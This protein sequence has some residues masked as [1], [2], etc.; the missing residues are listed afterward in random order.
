M[1]PASNSDGKKEAAKINI[2]VSFLTVSSL[3]VLLI[4]LP[5]KTYA[6]N[7]SC[8]ITGSGACSYVDT[9]TKSD[10]RHCDSGCGGCGP[11]PPPGSDCR[12]I[13]D[14]WNEY[15]CGWDPLDPDVCT[16]YC[17][18]W[19]RTWVCD[20][21]VRYGECSPGDTSSCTCDNGC[22]GTKTCQ[23][24][25]GWGPCENCGTPDT[26]CSSHPVTWSG[27]CVGDLPCGPGTESGTCDNGC[28]GTGTTSRECCNVCCSSPY[29][30]QD[31]WCGGTCSDSDDY[32]T[33]TPWTGTYGGDCDPSCGQTRTRTCTNACSED[34][35][36][37]WDQP[38][39]AESD[40]CSDCDIG[41][42]GAPD[43]LRPGSSSKSLP[44]RIRTSSGDT[45]NG[46][47]LSQTLWWDN[48]DSDRTCDGITWPRTDDY[49]IWVKEWPWGT[50]GLETTVVDG[51]TVDITDS[52]AASLSS[53][54][55]SYTLNAKIGYEYEWWT[56]GRNIH[57]SEEISAE[58]EHGFVCRPDCR[59]LDCGQNGGCG[60]SETRSDSWSG[61]YNSG[62]DDCY[63]TDNNNPS[64]PV[65]L[66]VS[67][68]A[69]Y[70]DRRLSGDDWSDPVILDFSGDSHKVYFFWDP[71]SWNSQQPEDEFMIQILDLGD[72]QDV[73][74]SNCCNP[75]NP[76]ND[77][78]CDEYWTEPTDWSKDFGWDVQV[79]GH[80]V[81]YD[82]ACS[83]GHC[84]WPQTGTYLIQKHHL[85]A[86]RVAAHNVT[87]ERD[88][89]AA[90][91]VDVSSNVGSLVGQ[92][93]HLDPD[94]CPNPDTCGGD[95]E[96]DW[97]DWT[98]G[99][100]M[101]LNQYPTATNVEPTCNSRNGDCWSG[102]TTYNPENDQTV[103]PW[104]GTWQQ[105]WDSPSG[106]GA[107]SCGG[108]CTPCA[109]FFT[110]SSCEAQLGCRWVGGVLGTSTGAGKDIAATHPPGGSFCSGDC[111]SCQDLT[112]DTC[113]DQNGCRLEDYCDAHSCQDMV[114][115]N[116]P[117]VFIAT[118][119][120]PDGWE[121]LRRLHLTFTRPGR[122]CQ[123]SKDSN[124]GW[125][126][127]ERTTSD[128][129]CD[130][131]IADA[132]G[133]CITSSTHDQAEWQFLGGKIERDS[134]S[135]NRLKGYFKVRFDRGGS[136]S[137]DG[138]NIKI[139]ISA[140]DFH[141]ASLAD[142]D[143]ITWYGDPSGHPDHPNGEVYGTSG[144]D[145]DYSWKIDLVPPQRDTSENDPM[146]GN[147]I[148]DL[149][150]VDVNGDGSYDTWAF[151]IKL[152]FRDFPFT[153]PHV[154]SKLFADL[155]PNKLSPDRNGNGIVTFEG[156]MG[157]QPPNLEEN[158]V[159]VLA[160]YSGDYNN[161]GTEEWIRLPYEDDR[162]TYP[163]YYRVEPRDFSGGSQV[164]VTL[165]VPAENEPNPISVGG[166]DIYYQ[167]TKDLRI[168]VRDQA[169]N[170]YDTGRDLS[171]FPGWFQAING[172][173]YARGE[174][175]VKVD[176]VTVSDYS[177]DY[178]TYFL[179]SEPSP[180]P[181]DTIPDTSG[182]LVL[183][184][185]DI[186]TGTT[187]RATER[188]SDSDHHRWEESHYSSSRL[189]SWSDALG[190]NWSE[191]V[192]SVKSS[193]NQLDFS[194]DIGS[195]WPKLTA[196]A[197]YEITSSSLTSGVVEGEYDLSG[198]GAAI[199]YVAG[200]TETTVDGTPIRGLVIG[201]GDKATGTNTFSSKDG[202]NEGVILIVDGDVYIR[203]DIQRVDAF[204]IATGSITFELGDTTEPVEVNGSL[205][206][207][208]GIDVSRYIFDVYKPVLRVKYNGLYISSA[209]GS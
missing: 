14:S 182:G 18:D 9:C 71:A 28:G 67:L 202:N 195:R 187:N 107:Q 76:D 185:S 100:S 99:Y 153:S 59:P 122:S 194:N 48:G 64:K 80:V 172:D 152:A 42:P 151:E 57:C 205:V 161:D 111:T 189:S 147:E 49:Q 52:S 168:R 38:K 36:D 33:C 109:F 184:G 43:N 17:C 175:N 181:T 176:A 75:D 103:W 46:S 162:G 129:S 191:M 113:R 198:K 117:V 72:C 166:H 138:G 70:D 37:G 58:S 54:N 193:G 25:C 60:E 192:S 6:A 125:I 39:P 61:F 97:S 145:D 203:R 77:P 141:T 201:D 169:G 7:Y 19:T 183:S 148:T 1:T 108:T 47:A 167:R 95:G 112:V 115:Q 207:K 180:P 186:D 68:T 142:D 11:P 121:D 140:D 69:S 91:A 81:G 124:L 132:A 88:E 174:I 170:V 155:D 119:E 32:W 120:D 98:V 89:G 118:Y 104:P 164:I 131:G 34:A 56:R 35:G 160:W 179:A 139:C 12:H 53:E 199:L 105:P 41:A 73:N 83:G 102:S 116:N 96:R 165:Y 30:G 123:A 82:E 150:Q 137:A 79:E 20:E 87:C 134:S 65:G 146:D 149:F 163:F 45:K 209:I 143:E 15:C 3:Y 27:N 190:F 130:G 93:D 31:N 13:S 40:T 66:G 24:D 114:S 29:C 74:G 206:A 159:S 110:Q 197:Y 171:L 26:D 8:G 86:F 144:S 55:G 208:E 78:I 200:T 196:S 62:D 22:P 133:S 126:S 23:S 204:I 21:L 4:L 188:P 106:A 92:M 177:D 158:E 135:A 63:W 10:T 84:M 90:Q 2:L 51:E 5:P 127:L 173:V 136:Y 44:E 157:D 85:V 128:S 154:E 94:G 156:E 16:A 101:M 50:S 178:D